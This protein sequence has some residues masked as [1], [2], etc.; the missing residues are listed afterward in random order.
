M[1]ALA[2]VGTA[3]ASAASTSCNAGGIIKL[4]PGLSSEPQVQNV[5]VKGTLAGCE[6]NESKVKTGKFVAHFR[7]P[8]RSAVTLTDGGWAPRRKRTASS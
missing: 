7:P 5:I 1:A 3:S 2:L 8:K 4:S 6:S